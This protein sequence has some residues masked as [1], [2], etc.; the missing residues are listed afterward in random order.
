MQVAHVTPTDRQKSPDALDSSAREF[1]LWLLDALGLKVQ[2][3]GNG[4]YQIEIPRPAAA[5][6]AAAGAEAEHPYAALEGRCFTFDQAGGQAIDRRQDTEY[7]TWQSPLVQWLLGELQS[8]TRLIHAAAAHQPLSVHELA[9]HLFAQYKVDQG[10]MHLAGCSLED[11]PFLRLSYLQPQPKNGAAQ[12]VHCFGT[13]D[14][15]LMDAALSETLDLDDLV[16]V[17]GRAPRIDSD[18]VRRWTD[19]TRQQYEAQQSDKNRSLV[20]ITLVWCKYVEGKLTFSIGQRTA[21]VPF[22]G[23]G[24]LFADRRSLPPPYRCPLSGKA[25]YHLGATDDGRITVAEAIATCYES[26]R[27]V[28]ADELQV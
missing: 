1:V 4:V 25:S 9:E 2:A 13:S 26:S 5:G 28:L 23:W 3:G 20:A 27:R 12:L 11:R 14:G 19:L 15:E 10:H 8:G 16:P 22:S 18:V 7:A 6:A 21:E 24:R 17:A